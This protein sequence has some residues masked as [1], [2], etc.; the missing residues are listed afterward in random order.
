MKKFTFIVAAL[1]AV[2]LAWAGSSHAIGLGDLNKIDVNKAV[3]GTKQIIEASKDITPSE[4]Y[5]IGR[6]VAA[7]IISRYP[8]VE[9]PAQ[10]TYLNEVGLTVA[11]ASDKPYTYGGYHF[12]VVKSDTPN[13]FACPGGIVLITTGLLKS[14]KSEDELAGVLAHEIA[15][16]AHSDGV[17]AIKKSQWTK[18]GVD[19]AVEVGKDYTP[20]QAKALTDAF[21]GTV[22]DV[23]KQVLESG[24]SKSA[25]KNADDSAVSYLTKA[26]YDPR[27][28]VA[29]LENVSKSGSTD[30]GKWLSTHSSPDKRIAALNSDIEKSGTTP[31]VDKART[32]R[33]ASS[34][35]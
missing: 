10:T 21:S 20:S 12:A 33:F 9:N 28:L 25:E 11:R 31:A 3:S 18:L 35:K 17:S 13:A 1:I 30:A 29:V 6:A 2:A 8:L 14:V 19:V 32:A 4:E 7:N 5:Y 34:V 15:H 22:A 23:T 26:G 16:V 27:A 24:Y